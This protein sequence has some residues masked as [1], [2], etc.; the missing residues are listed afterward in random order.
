MNRYKTELPKIYRRGG[1]AL[2][3]VS[4]H[5]EMV[6]TQGKNGTITAN[7]AREMSLADWKELCIEDGATLATAKIAIRTLI[8]FRSTF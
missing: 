5:I 4:A 7:S 1:S 2:H 3:H 8:V 6:K